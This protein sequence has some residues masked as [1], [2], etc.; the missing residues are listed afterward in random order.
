[1]LDPVTIRYAEA[2]FN[3]AKQN[4]QLEEVQR[5]VERFDAELE[6]PGVAA[7]VFDARVSM[8]TRRDKIQP[9]FQGASKVFHDF[10]NLLFDKRREEVLRD[11]RAAFHRRLLQERGGA[12]GVVESAMPLDASEMARIQTALGAR[13]GKQLSL[14]NRVVPELLGGV[15]VIVDNKMMDLSLRGRLDGLRKQMLEASLPSSSEA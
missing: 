1:M 15:R 6:R 10:A 13:L 2:L 12:E 7:F 11:L 3:L 8:N 4:G 5:D 14:E 9:F